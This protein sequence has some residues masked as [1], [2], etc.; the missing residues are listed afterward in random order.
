MNKWYVITGRTCS[1]KTTTI[2][3]LRERGIRTSSETAT[4]I[5]E[6]G[7]Q[8]GKTLKEIRKFDQEFQKRVLE[9]KIDF[10][11][12]IQKD[13]ICFFDR[14]IPDSVG[15]Y[16]LLHLKI[17]SYVENAIKN[18]FYK[19]IFFLEPLA[20]NVDYHRNEELVDAEKVS[21][22][23]LQ[24]YK[25]LPF[26]IVMVPVMDKEARVDYILKHL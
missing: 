19:K 6:E 7:L 25:S 20:Y 23:I 24:T 5:I 4:M 22:Y 14:G 11:N 13:E 10:E 15:F 21:G 2:E 18:C 26:P 3:L 17:D 12:S 9:R 1:G 16:T 8:S